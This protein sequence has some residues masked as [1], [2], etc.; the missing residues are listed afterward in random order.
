MPRGFIPRQPVK[1]KRRPL[2]RIVDKINNRSCKVLGRL[3]AG[4]DF[5][6][7]MGLGLGCQANFPLDINTKNSKYSREIEHSLILPVKLRFLIKTEGHVVE[8]NG[9]LQFQLR[10]PGS[11]ARRPKFH[12][13]LVIIRADGSNLPRKSA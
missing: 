9:G 7:F 2:D 1:A 5:L 11:Y 10:I 12:K 13:L 6:S 4:V 3:T 8:P